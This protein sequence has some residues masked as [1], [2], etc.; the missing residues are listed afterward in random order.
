MQTVYARLAACLVTASVICG[1]ASMGGCDT[2]VSDERIDNAIRQVGEEQVQLQNQ[3]KAAS[4]EAEK[5]DL[6]VQLQAA[7]LAAQQLLEIK[8]KLAEA[9]KSADAISGT[10][11]AI[12]SA[13]PIPGVN[14]VIA[15][16]GGTGI[17]GGIAS[18]LSRQKY[19]KVA[20]EILFNTIKALIESKFAIRLY[21]LRTKV[22]SLDKL[23]GME[24]TIAVNITKPLVSG[25]RGSSLST[26]TSKLREQRKHSSVDFSQPNCKSKLSS[27]VAPS[28]SSLL[29]PRPTQGGDVTSAGGEDSGTQ[30][31]IPTV[32]AGLK[33]ATHQ[34]YSKID[35]KR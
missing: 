28:S 1:T 25:G 5:A 27:S 20:N 7:N 6:N 12:G 16:L 3:I 34:L 4:T 10:I 21:A 13:V 23:G 18:W 11:T 32:D 8:Q 2:M 31:P 26:P 33:W 22:S 30:S 15:A 24:V 9:S 14:T 29:A 17:I 19:A 35:S